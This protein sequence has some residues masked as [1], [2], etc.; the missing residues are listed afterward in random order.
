[1]RASPDASPHPA[2]ASRAALAA[3]HAK[4]LAHWPTLALLALAVLAV[5]TLALRGQPFA[6]QPAAPLMPVQPL[7]TRVIAAAPEAAPP[8]P[9]AP[10]AHHPE[11][12]CHSPKSHQ[13]MNKKC[14]KPT[15]N[16][17]KQLLNK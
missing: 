11:K 16:V 14:L 4:P 5:H 10:G 13:T 7:D 3:A 1:M 8:S 15:Q 17:R 6:V 2:A 9:P 12:C